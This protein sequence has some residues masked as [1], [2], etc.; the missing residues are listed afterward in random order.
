[1]NTVERNGTLYVAL[2]D[3]E[4]LQVQLAAANEQAAFSHLRGATLDD[5][6]TVVGWPKHLWSDEDIELWGDSL[7]NGVKHSVGLARFIE[8]RINQLTER[9]V[10]AEFV[11]E[12]L[13]VAYSD[14]AGRFR[15][16]HIIND[17]NYRYD[18]K[19]DAARKEVA[20]GNG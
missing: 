4:A 3:Y 14:S 18:L 12:K 17:A 2:A 16:E 5:I 20:D 10:R 6:E 9:A 11:L 8:K 7:P 13:T 15:C 1:M 19:K